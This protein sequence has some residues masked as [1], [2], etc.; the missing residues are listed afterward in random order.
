MIVHRGWG[1]QARVFMNSNELIALANDSPLFEI[2]RLRV[3][4]SRCPLH[5]KRESRRHVIGGKIW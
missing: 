4:R 2:A 5:R 3:L 1:W